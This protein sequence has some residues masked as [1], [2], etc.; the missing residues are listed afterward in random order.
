VSVFVERL[1]PCFVFRNSVDMNRG[2]GNGSPYRS[3][4]RGGRGDFR[5]SGVGRGRGEFY[6]K[7]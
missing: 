2:R 3:F 1:P 5:A 6:S 4:D 7:R